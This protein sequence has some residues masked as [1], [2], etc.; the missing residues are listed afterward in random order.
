MQPPKSIGT[1]GI[2]IRGYL[3]QL[4]LIKIDMAQFDWAQVEQNPFFCP[5]ASK[6]QAMEDYMVALRA[7]GNSIGAKIFGGGNRLVSR[8]RRADF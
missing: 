4:G 8:L 7:E 5:D 1:K 6:V 2:L 3:S